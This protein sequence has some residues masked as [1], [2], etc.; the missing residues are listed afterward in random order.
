LTCYK[1]LEAASDPRAQGVLAA[2]HD[3]LLKQADNIPDA[4]LR[5]S[6]LC[7]IPEHREIVDVRSQMLRHQT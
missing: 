7:N 2:S 5:Q 1:V 3:L 6:F 4:A